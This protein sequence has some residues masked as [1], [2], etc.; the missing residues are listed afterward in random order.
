VSSLD[1]AIETADAVELSAGREEVIVVAEVTAALLREVAHE[2]KTALELEVI[3]AAA[4]PALGV[5]AATTLADLLGLSAG[6]EAV[7]AV[8][9]GVA[10]RRHGDLRA[11]HGLVHD[12]RDELVDAD[13]D[14]L[15]LAE[16]DEVFRAGIG[17]VSL[18][19]KDVRDV[20]LR[21][22]GLVLHGELG[23][24]ARSL[25]GVANEVTPGHLLE[26]GVTVLARDGRRVV[27]GIVEGVRED[28]L[29][30]A[31]VSVDINRVEPAV[32][33]ARSDIGAEGAVTKAS[34]RRGISRSRGDDVHVLRDLLLVPHGARVAS[35][36]EEDELLVHALLLPGVEDVSDVRVADE[37]TSGHGDD[38]RATVIV[39][40]DKDIAVL[41][42]LEGLSASGGLLTLHDSKEVLEVAVVASV[43][44]GNTLIDVPV[45]TLGI[46]DLIEHL[47]R[48]RI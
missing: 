37:L 39:V 34:I 18:T 33:P 3:S 22:G 26:V 10:D 44:L 36:H 45:L 48:E 43:V 28:G 7:A 32:R 25:S 19:G 14:L 35:G 8:V 23:D 38:A 2:L 42:R 16:S 21:S 24:L 46:I 15:L 9:A 13:T 47:S 6:L 30:G 5:V 12:V 1:V 4:S 29:E 31:L 27:L 17:L 41:V 40:V 11:G 20:V